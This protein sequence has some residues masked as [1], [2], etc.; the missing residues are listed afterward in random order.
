MRTRRMSNRWTSWLVAVLLLALGPA[1]AAWAQV[2]VTSADPPETTQGTVS[3][4]VTILG[5]GFDTT[6]AV[7]FLVTGT[8]NPGGIVVR[9]VVVHNSKKLVATI[10][11][12]E[13]AVLGQY[14][15]EVRLSSGRKGKGTTLFSISKKSVVVD[16]CLEAESRGFPAL[17][18]MRNTTAGGVV[19]W[20]MFLTDSS[21]SCERQVGSYSHGRNVSLRFDRD[22]GTGAMAHDGNGFGLVAATLSIGFDAAGAPVVQSSPFS[23]VLEPGDLPVPVGVPAGDWTLTIMGDPQISP[24]GTALLVSSSYSSP[25]MGQFIASWSCPFNAATAIVDKDG[26]SNVYGWLGSGFGGLGWSADGQSL[27]VT[28]D[29]QSGSGRALFRL[30]LS[31]GAFT[32]LW[33]RGT[34]LMGPK[35]SVDAQGRERVSVVERVSLCNKVLVADPATCNGS[36][37]TILNGAGHLAHTHT[38]LADGR[39]AAEGMTPPDRKGKCTLTGNIVVFDSTDTTGSVSIF[40]PSGSYPDGAD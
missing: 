24:D 22:S 39:L 16:P 12:A 18:F 34:H 26:C 29:A 11:A 2:K 21:G 13:S 33:S 38:W 3:L 17:F 4:D 37:C 6:A 5:S 23:K 19:S 28:Q 25:S 40:K 32:Q 31:D 7:S 30:R 20:G 8:T 35:A 15:I 14:D 10:D 9:K 27:Y 36:D 1:Q